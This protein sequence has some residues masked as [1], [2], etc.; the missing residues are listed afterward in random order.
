MR[1][2]FFKIHMSLTKNY[3]I[4]TGLV[5]LEWHKLKW[6]GL[7]SNDWWIS[8]MAGLRVLKSKTEPTMRTIGH[9]QL[10]QWENVCVSANEDWTLQVV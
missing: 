5:L 6:P 9:L 8:E 2:D 7:A 10:S 1:F 3:F 4:T